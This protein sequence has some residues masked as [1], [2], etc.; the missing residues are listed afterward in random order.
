MASMAD[1]DIQH[2]SEINGRTPFAPSIHRTT[3]AA[4]YSKATLHG[5]ER[6]QSHTIAM[7]HVAISTTHSWTDSR[8]SMMSYGLLHGVCTEW[9]AIGEVT[10]LD[11][12]SKG[13]A[14][15][16]HQ[17]RMLHSNMST[18]QRQ[19]CHHQH[20]HSSSQHV[21]VLSHNMHPAAVVCEFC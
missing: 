20:A 21:K 14:S 15:L 16:L 11:R 10:G 17:V 8:L 5:H 9:L 12:L 7:F 3:W 18:A 4:L 1:V 13:F 2:Q 6:M 19:G